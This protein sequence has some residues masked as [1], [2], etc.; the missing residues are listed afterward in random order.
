MLTGLFHLEILSALGYV[1]LRKVPALL[2]CGCVKKLS[3]LSETSFRIYKRIIIPSSPENKQTASVSFLPT[4]GLY[5]QLQAVPLLLSISGRRWL[6]KEL[7]KWVSDF[8]MQSYSLV[9][10]MKKIRE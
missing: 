8:C 1:D 4:G 6:Q 5:T 3:N 2:P 7:S 10:R 9:Q